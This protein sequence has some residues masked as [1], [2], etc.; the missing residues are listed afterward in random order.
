MLQTSNSPD[1]PSMIY[2]ET[3][4]DDLLNQ[5]AEPREDFQQPSQPQPPT[6]D[7]QPDSLLPGQSLDPEAAASDPS[8]VTQELTAEEKKEL[9]GKRQFTAKFL[10]KNTDRAFAF[11][12]ALI[13]DSDDVD[14]WKAS[15]DDLDDIQEC[16]FEMCQAYGW[17]GLP[18]WVSLILCLTFTYGPAMKEAFKVRGINKELAA[19]A[20]R[21]EADRL[22]EAEARRLENE[23]RIE[24][25]KELQSEKNKNDKTQ[26]DQPN[27]S[28]SLTA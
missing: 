6:P 7:S 17:S 23:K 14:E 27:Q 26:T 18:P 3:P 25:E 9:K 10:A 12:N 4:L 1:R 16:Y 8:G 28:N 20:A 5:Y 22:I 21:A 15:H 13:A 19:K 11:L 24:A 2:S